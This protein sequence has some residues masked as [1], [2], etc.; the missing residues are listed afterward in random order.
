MVGTCG[1]LPVHAVSLALGRLAA[2]ADDA[3]AAGRHFDEAARVHASV[4][5]PFGEAETALHWGRWLLT[6]D[7]ERSRRLLSDAAAR[8]ERHGFATTRRRAEQELARS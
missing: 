3:I 4:H 1:P 7:P 8:A 6:C 2:L 5:C